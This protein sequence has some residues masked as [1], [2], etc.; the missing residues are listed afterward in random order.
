MQIFSIPYISKWLPGS[1]IGINACE[2]W[3]EM[4]QLIG[5]NNFGF[6]G[7]SVVMIWEELP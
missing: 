6:P 2:I 5:N 3:E 1:F 7:S 4:F